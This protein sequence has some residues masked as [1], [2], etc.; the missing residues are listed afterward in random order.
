MWNILPC[1]SFLL[2]RD[3]IHEIIGYR[4]LC[5]DVMEDDNHVLVTCPFTFSCWSKLKSLVL[6]NRCLKSLAGLICVL[7]DP[8]INQ[9]EKA[10]LAITSWF[11]WFARNE[12]IHESSMQNLD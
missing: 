8:Q 4:E 10:T 9:M 6:G 1:K 12:R 7:T 2:S 11:I 5:P 3:I